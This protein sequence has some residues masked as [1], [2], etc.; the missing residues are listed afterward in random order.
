MSVLSLCL[1]GMPPCLMSPLVWMMF[2][3]LGLFGLVLLSLRSLMRLGSVV[4]HFLLGAWFLAGV[5]L[6]LRIVQLGGPRVR[7][8]RANVADA[9]GAADVFLYRDLSVA[10]LLDM[11]RR[12]KAV[13]DLL[14]AM[15]RHG[16]S[17][18]RVGG[19]HCTVG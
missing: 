15:I 19:A 1:V 4:V 16:V 5:V 8:A 3:W 9:L 10:P 14:G 12:F 7:R 17:L 13:M 2:L 11:R 6:C 18:P